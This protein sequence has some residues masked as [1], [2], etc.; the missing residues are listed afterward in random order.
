VKASVE[1]ADPKGVPS[2]ALIVPAYQGVR[3]SA[4]ASLG[5]GA[6]RSAERALELGDF[7][8]RSAQVRFLYSADGE[9]AASRLVLVGLGARSERNAS[10]LRKAFR[11][12]GRA[13]PGRGIRTASLRFLPSQVPVRQLE[14]T[15]QVAVEGLDEACYRFTGRRKP[16]DEDPVPL[17]RLILV[18][19]DRSR[20]AALGRAARRGGEI[21]RGLRTA[22]DLS[23]EPGNEATPAKMAE[24]ARAVARAAGLECRI[25][26]PA[27]IRKE[28]LEALMAVARGAAEEPRVIVLRHAGRRA[29]KTDVALI[30]K[31]ITFDSGGISLKSPG[32]MVWM[33]FDKCGGAAVIGA[34]E[35]IG[36]LGLKRNVV[37][38]VPACE[39]LPDARAFK[40]GDV[41]SSLSGTT[42]EIKSTD[43]E[44]R[45]ILADAITYARNRFEPAALIDVATLTGAVAVALGD[46]ATGIMGNSPDLVRRVGRAGDSCGERVWELPLWKPYRD[47]LRSEVADLRNAVDSKGGAIIAGA[48]L[49]HFVGEVPWVHVDIAGTAWERHATGN[50]PGMGATGVGVRLLVELLDGMS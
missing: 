18:D 28:G 32:D 21:A 27:G 29:R 49:Q 20:S 26:G 12:V 1:K 42:I 19:P 13:L 7:T 22:K 23:N 30:G 34:M 37:G 14:S 17:E 24:R 43:A 3:G 47:R 45:L 9:I 25:L 38:I 33:K 40:P 41:I 4:F 5:A 35:A 46:V 2:D 39:N 48:F 11:S 36:R 10:S 8:G 50:G 16:D 44:G 6:R 15:A 31:G